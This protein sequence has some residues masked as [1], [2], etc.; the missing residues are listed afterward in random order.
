MGFDKPRKAGLN[1]KPPGVT[2]RELGI[3]SVLCLKCRETVTLY[4]S[5]RY[6]TLAD[7]GHKCGT[8]FGRPADLPRGEWDLRAPEALA[9]FRRAKNKATGALPT[10]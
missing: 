2:S 3:R 4:P 7:N 10:A 9:Q 5:F 1:N 6:L 8:G